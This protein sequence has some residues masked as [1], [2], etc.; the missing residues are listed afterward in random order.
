MNI[1]KLFK[2]LALCSCFI[3]TLSSIIPTYADSKNNQPLSSY[4]SIQSGNYIYFAA[5]DKLYK[6]N[7]KTK[8]STR[9]L[10]MS[11]SFYLC[12]VNVYNGYIYF[13]QYKGGSGCS[14]PY[15]YKIKTNGTRL[16]RLAKGDNIQIYNNKIYFI[17][18]N[19]YSDEEMTMSTR[20]IYRMSTTGTSL[21]AIKSS[22]LIE[23]FFVKN[24]YIYFQSSDIYENNSVYRMSINGKKTI[25]LYYNKSSNIFDVSNV[26]LYDL[27]PTESGYSAYKYSFSK[28][29]FSKILSCE[30]AYCVRNAWIYYTVRKNDNEYLYKFNLET[31]KKVLLAIDNSIT[32]VRVTSS[33]IVF[34]RIT[35][36][37]ESNQNFIHTCITDLNGNKEK[38]IAKYYLP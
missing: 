20:G 38:T 37:S 4:N 32:N 16:K 22:S 6:V 26:N 29:S 17:R 18:Y 1:K 33:N 35:E 27:I 36:P 2:T 14:V 15:I 10:T 12:D 31:K 28:K 8:K 13:V 3:F 9:I 30:S 24:N 11:D 34:D 23:K 5:G 7:T 21:I 19:F 25:R